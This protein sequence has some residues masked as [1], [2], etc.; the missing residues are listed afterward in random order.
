V[1]NGIMNNSRKESDF[2]KRM[3][4]KEREQYIKRF[5]ASCNPEELIPFIE[6]TKWDKN[7]REIEYVINIP[8]V[9]DLRD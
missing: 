5:I 4:S 8:S 1:K 9:I 7:F 6:I 2:I 3:S